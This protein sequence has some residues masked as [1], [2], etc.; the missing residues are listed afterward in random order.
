MKRQERLKIQKRRKRR[1]IV[2]VALALLLIAGLVA[3]I[4][5]FD[6]VKTWAGKHYLR[7]RI[8]RDV[9]IPEEGNEDLYAAI[10]KWFDP[11][12]NINVLFIGIDK[13]SVPGEEGYTRSDVM[14]LA[15]VNVQKKKAVLVS[16]PR[17]TRVNI[18]GF[19]TEKINAAHSFSGPAGAVEVVEQISGIDINDYAEVDFE[20]FKNIVDAIGG[21]T[22]HLDYAISD[23]KVGY[24]PKGDVFLTGETGLIL[25]RS[26]ELPR[27]DLD[28][29]DNQKKFLKAMMEKIVE[30][31]D[32]QALLKI[33][34]ATVKYLDTTLQPD[35]IFTLA[36]AL[37]G[38]KVED[39]EFITLPGDEPDPAPGQPWYY[40]HDPEAAT[41]LFQNIKLY[42]SIQTPEE[43]A[44]EAAQ[45][46]L[47][48]NLTELD[49]AADPSSVN[50]AVLNGVR[51]EGMATQIA[52]IMA[53]KGYTNISTG[54][55]VNPYEETTVYYAPGFEAAARMV[56]GDLNPGGD[57]VIEED[58]DVAITYD[59]DVILVIGNDYVNE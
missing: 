11:S 50:L 44:A 33:L 19:G 36:E 45:Q 27:G 55:T 56:A 12:E 32:M 10:N 34:D 1:T 2:K 31:K 35:L 15:S 26:R 24:L 7:I 29:I 42:C 37:G 23:P 38:M 20:A 6:A 52:E 8:D 18:P 41:A 28:R 54:N 16:F 13:G 53:D 17:D 59:A 39:V 58:A 46:Q 5:N 3:G 25:V 14:I 4:M 49:T 47:Q 40:I 51:W 21:V 43:Q 9:V 48:D 22:L 57:Y 30:V